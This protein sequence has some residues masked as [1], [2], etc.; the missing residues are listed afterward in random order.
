MQRLCCP[1]QRKTPVGREKRAWGTGPKDWTQKASV[2]TR[3]GDCTW[4]GQVLSER[5]ARENSECFC[6]LS[7]WYK[8]DWLT[9]QSTDRCWKHSI[10]EQCVICI[11]HRLHKFKVSQYVAWPHWHDSGSFRSCK[12]LKRKTSFWKGEGRGIEE[13]YLAGLAREQEHFER[14]EIKGT[15][16]EGFG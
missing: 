14:L 5:L 11:R 1:Q 3:E 9:F 4:A 15:R 8:R 7:S 16:L 10:C 6:S 12:G 13:K 2:A